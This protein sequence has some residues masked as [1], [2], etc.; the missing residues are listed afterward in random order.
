MKVSLNL[1]M[2]PASMEKAAVEEGLDLSKLSQIKA[3]VEN[4][5]DRTQKLINQ[6]EIEQR[7]K[8]E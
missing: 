6:L 4:D 5:L 1:D 3:A 2:L 8:S 7:T